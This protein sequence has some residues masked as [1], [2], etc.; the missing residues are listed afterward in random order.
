MAEAILA[1]YNIDKN[2]IN[3]LLSLQKEKLHENN[4]NPA[5]VT[6]ETIAAAY[7]R[8]SRS[9]EP[10]P[11]LRKQAIDEVEKARKSN[12]AIIFELGH[13]SVA[14]HAYFNFDILHLSRL[15]V[16]FFE[17]FR[18]ASFTEKSQRYITL[19][20]DYVTPLELI[21]TKYIESYHNLIQE[22]N[23]AYRELYE[24]LVPYF[25]NKYPEIAQS[26]GGKRT[27]DGWAKEDAR[28]TLALATETQLGMSVNA[29]TL[30]YMIASSQSHP[31]QEI[32]EL[33][34]QLYSLVKDIAPSLL[35]YPK[36]TAFLQKMENIYTEPSNMKNME[37]I[38]NGGSGNSPDVKFLN[39]DNADEKEILQALGF[40]ID[41]NEY[42]KNTDYKK[43]ENK[44]NEI[45]REMQLWDTPPRAFEWFDLKFEIV[46]SSSAFAQL[47]RHRISTQ[48]SQPYNINLGITI[49]PSIKEI[50]E[51]KTLLNITRK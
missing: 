30:E 15:G 5:S 48:I 26:K 3:S 22:Q 39:S 6:P 13:S 10:I 34:K 21:N 27:L 29:R 8:I 1:G 32:Q 33:G 35:K 40:S 43:Y 37:K 2:I 44:L 9:P 50:G 46:L 20:G 36:S 38:E 47:K 18:L 23:Q 28:Y 16:E 4:I 24:K 7:A 17:R 49:P 41:Q 19:D 42:D 12:R 14:E 11:E 45:F 31:L 25:L 51:E